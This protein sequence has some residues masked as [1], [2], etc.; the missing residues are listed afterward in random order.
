MS[1]LMEEFDWNGSDK[2]VRKWDEENETFYE[3][4]CEVCDG[5]DLG[6]MLCV[7]TIFNEITITG[8]QPKKGWP[9]SNSTAA[10]LSFK[11]RT[12]DDL[13]AVNRLLDWADRWAI[14]IE[15]SDNEIAELLKS[16][17]VDEVVEIKQLVDDIQRKT[18]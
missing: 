3:Y 5:P 8:A 11:I 6:N 17:S 14:V 12:L 18:S 7:P 2:D 10:I 9:A 15:I 13:R 16:L 1:T 4:M